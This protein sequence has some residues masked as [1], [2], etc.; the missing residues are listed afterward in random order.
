MPVLASWNVNSVKARLPNILSWLERE[1]PDIVGLQELKCLEDSF[2]ALD[3][4]SAGYETAA[5]GQKSYNGVALLAKSAIKVTERALPGNDDDAE[6]RYIEADIDGLRIG[7]LYLP[8]GNGAAER[9]SYKIDWMR[10]LRAHAAA[11]FDAEIPFALIGDYNV[12][13]EEE[14]CYDPGA[15]R[16]DALFQPEA[17]QEFQGLLNLGLTDAFRTLHSGEGHYT[18]WDYQGGMW[19]RDEG[20]RIDHIVLSPELADR[21]TGC[22]IDRTPRGQEKASD[23]TPI[24]CSLAASG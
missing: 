5:V 4:R 17:R 12:I 11:L 3:F 9:F 18:F 20:I 10:R 22:R 7:N 8:N 16:D 1:Q 14:D 21:L 24:L 6:A 23:H 2:P 13:P 19:Q 15:W